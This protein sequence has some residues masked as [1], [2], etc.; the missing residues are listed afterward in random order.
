MALTEAQKRYQNSEKG[1][2]A[3]ARYMQKRKAAMKVSKIK[4]EAVE[5]SE[6]E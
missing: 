1:R 3:R 4:K 2:A 5:A 6:E